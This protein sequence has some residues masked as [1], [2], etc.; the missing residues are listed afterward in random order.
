MIK[1]M[2]KWKRCTTME[3]TELVVSL[4]RAIGVMILSLLQ[5]LGIWKKA[6]FVY[7]TLLGVWMLIQAHQEWKQNNSRLALFS[8]LCAL[9]LAVCR[10][11]VVILK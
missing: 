8:L 2:E 10:I 7:V 11:A 3:K 9:F 1:W 5:V 4:L 6:A